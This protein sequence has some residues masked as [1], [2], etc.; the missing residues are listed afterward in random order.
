MSAESD[1]EFERIIRGAADIL[2]AGGN[3]HY[4]SP[5]PGVAKVVSL[6]GAAQK[7]IRTAAAVTAGA[8]LAASALAYSPEAEAAREK[9]PTEKGVAI[10]RSAQSVASSVLSGQRAVERIDRGLKRGDVSTVLS[11]VSSVLSA[12]DRAY[13]KSSAVIPKSGAAAASPTPVQSSS[14]SPIGHVLPAPRAS[15]QNTEGKGS[16]YGSVQEFYD[17]FGATPR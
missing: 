6:I 1:A 9:R 14:D 10:A 13:Q 17:D 8:S 16:S 11:G 3:V 2:E 5:R 12:T 7:V 4:A 15:A